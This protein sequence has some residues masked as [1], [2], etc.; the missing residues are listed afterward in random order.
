MA[1]FEEGARESIIPI[2]EAKAYAED[3]GRVAEAVTQLEK[4]EGWKIFLSLFAQKK[5]E[6]KDR[7]DYPDIH[8]FKA[9]RAAIGIVEDIIG[10]FQGYAEDASRAKDLFNKLSDAEGQTPTTGFSIDIS[11]EGNPEA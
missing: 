4:S 8:A 1:I 5:R 9:D 2:E 10:T 7:E 6:I 11:G 3:T